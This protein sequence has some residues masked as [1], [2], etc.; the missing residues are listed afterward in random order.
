RKKRSG[1]GT[2]VRAFHAVS[3]CVEEVGGA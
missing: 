2:R 3:A 1:C